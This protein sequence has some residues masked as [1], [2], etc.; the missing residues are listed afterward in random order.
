M[1][2]QTKK[3]KLTNIP[4]L[5]KKQDI[6]NSCLVF[7]KIKSVK[8]SNSGVLSPYENISATVKYASKKSAEKAADIGCVRIQ[9]EP[10]KVVSVVLCIEKKYNYEELKKWSQ[11]IK[12][13]KN[14]S[15]GKHSVVEKETDIKER[16][17][18]FPSEAPKSTKYSI[19]SIIE[20]DQLSSEE[21]KKKL[22]L[23]IN[24]YTKMVME[25]S[26]ALK[27]NHE[28]ENVLFNRSV[29]KTRA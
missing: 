21:N 5:S 23:K 26:S 12:E 17:L 9:P 22:S 29:Y 27:L 4:S 3:I 2:I 18:L 16:V 20:E 7:G 14:Q 8:I 13:K 28:D 19:G 24:N 25:R 11:L 1:N 6:I 10:W 15:H